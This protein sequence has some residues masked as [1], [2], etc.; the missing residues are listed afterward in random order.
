M[1]KAQ[2][3]IKPLSPYSV[4]G[5]CW[6]VGRIVSIGHVS[7]QPLHLLWNHMFCGDAIPIWPVRVCVYSI[8]AR[9]RR[10]SCNPADTTGGNVKGEKNRFRRNFLVSKHK[11]DAELSHSV[12]PSR[13][14]SVPSPN[15]ASSQCWRLRDLGT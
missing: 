5:R 3:T 10:Q 9:W 7:S 6:L 14:Q 11:L 4:F 12:I 2:T 1:T 13:Q 8:L 15:G